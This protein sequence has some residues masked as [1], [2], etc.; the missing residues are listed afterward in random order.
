MRST[1]AHPCKSSPLYNFY[2]TLMGSHSGNVSLNITLASPSPFSHIGDRP[3]PDAVNLLRAAVSSSQNAFD[4]CDLPPVSVDVSTS[5]GDVTLHFVGWE[6]PFRSLSQ[7][8]RTSVGFI[9]G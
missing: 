8:V 2:P 4:V 1:S 3:A 6:Q 9:K 7:S 5:T